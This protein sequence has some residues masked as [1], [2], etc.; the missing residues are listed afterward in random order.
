MDQWEVFIF[1][2]PD[3]DIKFMGSQF[4]N[5]GLNQCPT[6]WKHRA[7]TT[8]LPGNFHGNPVS[9]FLLL[10]GFPGGSAGKE[11]A[12]QCRRHKRCELDL[13]VGKIPW[14][15]EWQPS[16]IFFWNILWTE[17]PG[18]LQSM[19]LQRVG[20][21]LV[22]EQQHQVSQHLRSSLMKTGRFQVN[23]NPVTLLCRNL[24]NI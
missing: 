21:D 14:R 3:H 5:Q 4:H 23:W 9:N 20:H 1:F 13:W 12:C 15:R 2:S 22:T 8:G 24:R 18:R 17:E 7:L 11:S 19:C 10:K 16:P 6:Q